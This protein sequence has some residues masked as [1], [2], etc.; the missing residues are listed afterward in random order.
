MD[1]PSYIPI[2]V[3][4]KWEDTRLILYPLKKKKNPF[5]FSPHVCHLR[6]FERVFFHSSRCM[7]PHY[8]STFKGNLQSI[9]SLLIF[10]SSALQREKH[11]QPNQPR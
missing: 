8:D 1:P 3:R 4:W 10:S 5:H 11:R 6:G 9:G 7:P 2:C